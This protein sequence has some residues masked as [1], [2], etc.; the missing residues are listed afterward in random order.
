MLALECRANVVRSRAAFRT[1][2]NPDETTGI[3]VQK[4]SSHLLAVEPEV[5]RCRAQCEPLRQRRLDEH[6]VLRKLA[7]PLGGERPERPLRHNQEGKMA[8]ANHIGPP[9]PLVEV[10]KG[11][12]RSRRVHDGTF[13]W[14][15][16]AE[17]EL[18]ESFAE[19]LNPREAAF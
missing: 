8:A 3:K 13:G 5:P 4:R 17:I 19:L 14:A 2:L 12:D 9:D 6:S 16:L 18:P 1:E 11:L 10:T 15:L 7:D